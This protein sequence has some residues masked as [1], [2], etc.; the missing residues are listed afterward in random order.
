MLE[1][2]GWILCPFITLAVGDSYL[3]W[4]KGAMPEGCAGTK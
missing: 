4:R 2:W 3:A 1:S